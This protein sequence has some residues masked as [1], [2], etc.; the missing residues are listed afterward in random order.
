MASPQELAARKK[1]G[2]QQ[3]T[4]ATFVPAPQGGIN[5]ISGAG[6]VPENDALFL[7]NLIPQEYGVHVRK[8]YIEWCQPIPLGDGVKT[9][10]PLS[11][12]NSDAPV[13]KLFAATSDG[14]YDVTVQGAAPIKM[15]DWP[16]KTERSGWVSWTAYTT[17]AG[18][19]IL[20]CD[21]E[22]GYYVY[23]TSTNT[24]AVGVITG[25]T[26]AETLLD[27][28]MVWKNRVWFVEQSS[29]RAWYLPVGQITGSATSFEFGNKFRYGGYL[30]SMWSWTVDAGVGI[31]DMMVVFSSAGDMLVYKGT[32]PQTVGT[33][34]QVGSW[35]VGKPTQGRRQG[36]DMGGDLLALTNY[37]LLQLSKMIAGA[38]AQ[39]TTVAMS[40]KV[41]A[42]LNNVLERGNTVYGWQVKLSPGDQLIF[43]LVPKEAGRSWMQF[44]YSTT[45]RAWCQFTD[46]PMKC[47]EVYKNRLYFGSDTNRVFVYDGIVDNV[48]LADSGASARTIQW[49]MLTGY[50]TYGDPA[51][52]KRVQFLRPRFIGSEIPAYNIQARYDFDLSPLS[53]PPPTFNL[54]FGRW[55]LSFWDSAVWAG[56]SIVTQAPQ[57]GFGMGQH[58]AIAMRGQSAGQL[59]Y[60]GTDIFLDTGGYL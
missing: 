14:I 22:N 36:D 24:W 13:D 4:Q 10:I 3:D 11:A 49:E 8:G 30:K 19:F 52:W 9:I 2:Q 54:Q 60:L 26:P 56:D 48:L 23:T 31:D 40:Y 42:R 7:Y 27:F 43:V 33:F 1:R 39:D 35:Y 47:A 32:D 55:D 5:A 20:A 46:V 29:G 12:I 28:V 53:V 25:P 45:T 51:K 59:I 16:I 15:L 38:A 44:V 17:I 37:G 41:N 58:I 21:N 57:G 18:Q 6:S 50:Q 34:E